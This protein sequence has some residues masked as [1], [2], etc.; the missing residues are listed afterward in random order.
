MVKRATVSLRETGSMKERPML[1]VSVYE[2]GS[3]HTEFEG[4]EEIKAEMS[5]T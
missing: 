1:K 3:E 4:L 5:S 2:F